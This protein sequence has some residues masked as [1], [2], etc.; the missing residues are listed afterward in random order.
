[1][2]RLSSTKIKH[3]RQN[4]PGLLP[5][6][7]MP[8]SWWVMWNRQLAIKEPMESFSAGGLR[9]KT[10]GQMQCRLHRLNR[11]WECDNDGVQCCR[12]NHNV[13]GENR[14]G[15]RM[16][17]N[18]RVHGV[19]INASRFGVLPPL[20]WRCLLSKGRVK[21]PVMGQPSWQIIVSFRSL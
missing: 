5:V 16:D 19:N 18:F 9:I 20:L 3:T 14:P 2:S 8:K 10:T 4:G 17:M 13:R 21:D 1:M 7:T 15:I 6:E 11:E 12:W